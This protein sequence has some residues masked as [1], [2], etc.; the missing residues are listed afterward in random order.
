MEPATAFDPQSAPVAPGNAQPN[1]GGLLDDAR[2]LWR[3]LLGLVHD[4]LALAAL[5]TKAAGKSLVSMV[6]ANMIITTLPTN[7]QPKPTNTT[8]L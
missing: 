3:E 4:Q 5:E 6:V 8:I 1:G 7:T 2:S